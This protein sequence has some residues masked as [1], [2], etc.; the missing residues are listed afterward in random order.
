MLPK[1]YRRPLRKGGKVYIYW[2]SS[3]DPGAIQIGRFEG[4]TLEEA[5]KAEREGAAQLTERY[6]ALFAPKH[7]P[8]F[9][10][11]L[12]RDFM[13]IRVPEMAPSTQ[14]VWKGHLREIIDFFGDTSLRGMQQKPDQHGKGTSARAL[15]K[16]WHKKVAGWDADLKV[17]RHPRT[18]NYRLTVLARVL[19]WAKD[20]ERI[21][22]NAAEGIERLNEGPGRAAIT[23]KPDELE[24]FLKLCPAPVARG[25]RMAALTGLRMKDVVELTWDQV[26]PNVIR[27]PTSKS[28]GKQLAAIPLYPALRLL[29]DECKAACPEVGDGRVVVNGKGRGWKSADSFDS[30][31]RP[32]IAAY[33]KAGGADKHF[34]DLRGNAATAMYLGGVNLRQIGLAMGWSE[35]EVPNRIND[36]VDLT[37][38][39]RA[40]ASVS[41]L[42]VASQ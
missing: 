24:A 7:N 17:Y 18:A 39:A 16:A 29:L 5:Q 9:M 41:Q 42:P 8:D 34:H 21:Q 10:S 25:I 22:Y 15:I 14:K 35:G 37:E 33:R 40:M 31:M 1:A 27:R 4:A 38:A 20:E 32:S 12:V 3:R 36:Y 19:S 2:Y 23:W 13:R 11:A 30:S 26:E 28:R 6:A